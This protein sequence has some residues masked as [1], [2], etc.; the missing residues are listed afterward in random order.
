MDFLINGLENEAGKIK[1]K[2]SKMYN[3]KILIELLVSK[4]PT[5]DYQNS[6]LGKSLHNFCYNYSSKTSFSPSNYHHSWV[7]TVTVNIILFTFLVKTILYF[8]FKNYYYD[9]RNYFYF[10]LLK[11]TVISLFQCAYHSGE[12]FFVFWA[13]HRFR[14]KNC[15]Y[16]DH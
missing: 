7:L 12:D 11:H 13:W 6:T 1:T 10:K 4:I 8:R 16:D 5:I 15:H 9:N 14:F 2:M 3:N